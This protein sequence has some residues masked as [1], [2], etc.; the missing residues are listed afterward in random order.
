[1]VRVGLVEYGSPLLL[2]IQESGGLDIVQLFLQGI[3]GEM[4]LPLRNLRR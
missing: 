4:N 1:M 3:G 2:F